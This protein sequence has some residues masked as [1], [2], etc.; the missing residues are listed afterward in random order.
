MNDLSK[1]KKFWCK[2]SVYSD[3]CKTSSYLTAHGPLYDKQ[4]LHSIRELLIYMYMNV[5]M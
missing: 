2:N 3:A 4:Q 1:T 5:N